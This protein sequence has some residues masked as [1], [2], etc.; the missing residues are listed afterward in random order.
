[1][2]ERKNAHANGLASTRVRSILH[3]LSRKCRK[4]YGSSTDCSQKWLQMRLKGT[5]KPHC[6]EFLFYQ[7][8][9]ICK[10]SDGG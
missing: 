3:G 10:L 5:M 4:V 2:E 8:K 6:E 1:M 9:G 7:A